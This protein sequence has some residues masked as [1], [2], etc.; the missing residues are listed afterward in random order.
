RIFFKKYLIIFIFRQYLIAQHVH[1]CLE[2]EKSLKS[3][4][5]STSYIQ[6]AYELWNSIVF[7]SNTIMN[8][9]RDRLINLSDVQSSTAITDSI[10]CLYI[11]QNT[12]LKTLFQDYISTR[13]NSICQILDSDKFEPNINLRDRIVKCLDFLVSTVNSFYSVFSANNEDQSFDGI[14]NDSTFI[15]EALKDDGVVINKIPAYL[16]QIY[17]EKK[18]NIQK[19]DL[20]YLKTNCGQWLDNC[21]QELRTKLQKVFK[22]VSNLKSLVLIRD[23]VLDFETN[24]LNKQH[25]SE[26]NSGPNWDSLCQLLFDKNIS[27]WNDLISSFYYDQSKLIIDSSFQSTHDNLIYNLQ[28]CLNDEKLSAESD[29]NSLL[30]SSEESENVAKSRAQ[31]DFFSSHSLKL[32]RNGKNLNERLIYSSTPIIKKLCSS[33]EEDVNKI[34]SDIE[35]STSGSYVMSTESNVTILTNDFKRFN[36]YLQDNLDHF[37]DNVL[38]SLV[39]LIDELSE[40]KSE[41]HIKKILLVCRLAHALP[42]NCPHLKICFNNLNQQLIQQRQQIMISSRQNVETSTSALLSALN[43]RKQALL[44][45]KVTKDENWTKLLGKLNEVLKKGLGIWIDN[46]CSSLKDNLWKRLSQNENV[47]LV[48]DL[49]TWDEIEIEDEVCL[50]QPEENSSVTRIQSSESKSKLSVPLVCSSVIQNLL[51]SLSQ[52]IAKDLPYTMID[53]NLILKDLILN[54]INFVLEVYNNLLTL[55]QTVDKKRIK[56]TQNQ[57]LQMLFDIKFLHT[58]FDLKPSNYLNSTNESADRVET[59]NKIQQDFKEICSRVESLIDPFDYDI[60]VPFLQS[61]ISKAISRYAFLFG[62][63]NT[64]ERHLRT[65]SNLQSKVSSSNE[66]YNLIVLSSNQH[67]FELLPIASQQAQQAQAKSKTI[68]KLKNQ[69]GESKPTI[70]KQENVSNSLFGIKWF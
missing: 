38:S 54:V 46:L 52:Q 57:S 66:K 37:S 7:L 29:I 68:A 64:N 65:M 22:Y 10:C 8:K 11:L 62:I 24:L 34:L 59:F 26:T 51:H 58:L 4:Q 5:N 13:T 60:C 27:I 70:A 36:E 49:V 33:L 69:P 28:Q 32:Q 56:I 35:I 47:L 20:D 39:K 67:R 16:K 48:N 14:I 23:S 45:N 21:V 53:A 25:L 41:Q 43:K 3:G 63:L 9:A 1:S 17:F 44:E 40:S 19:F 61:N 6:Y 30:W 2:L 42:H 15:L 18:Q 12:D 50:N 55:S 31:I